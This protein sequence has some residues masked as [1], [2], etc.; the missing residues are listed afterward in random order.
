MDNEKEI[1]A[2]EAQLKHLKMCTERSGH[3][4]I[5]KT[6]HMAKNKKAMRAAFLT[7]KVWPANTTIKIAFLEK[8]GDD[9]DRTDVDV[10][11]RTVDAN[12]VSLYVDPMQDIIDKFSITDAIIKVV[13]ERMQPLVNIKLKFYD[14]KNKLYNPNVADI[15]IAFDPNGG[16]WSL[17]GTDALT[18]KNKKEA[19]MNLGWFDVPTTCHEFCHAL[20]MIHEHSNPKGNKINWNVDRV[21]KWAKDSQGWDAAT[22]K[23]NIIDRYNMDEI[24]G[25]SFDPTSIMLYFF[26]G[27]LTDDPKTKKCCGTGTHQNLSFA[28]NDVLFLNHTYPLANTNMTSEQFTVKWFNDKYNRKI[29]EEMLKKEI[30]EEDKRQAAIKAKN[31]KSDNRKKK[32]NETLMSDEDGTNPIAAQHALRNNALRN[33]GG[34]NEKSDAQEEAIVAAHALRTFADKIDRE[35]N[36]IKNEADRLEQQAVEP[37]NTFDMLNNVIYGLFIVLCLYLLYEVFVKK[38]KHAPVVKV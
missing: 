34:E 32:S 18:V 33:F 8:P 15:R 38:S 19:T 16:A 29:D 24:N 25:S 36:I 6:T 3:A 11:K 37:M 13:T 21:Y 4:K 1:K 35:S 22:T 7:A 10:M 28:P 14:E 12:G 31:K 5:K 2:L 23:T 9:I 26:P 27:T 30:S 20:G 17:L